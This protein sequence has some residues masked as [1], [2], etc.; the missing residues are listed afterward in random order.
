MELYRSGFHE[1]CIEF[2]P[3][4]LKKGFI[5]TPCVFL[6]VKPCVPS[7]LHHKRFRVQGLGV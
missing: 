2:G 5:R 3:D 1:A 4:L 7:S 6:F